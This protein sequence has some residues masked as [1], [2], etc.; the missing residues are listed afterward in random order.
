MRLLVTGSR[1]WKD[2]E[3]L[4]HYLNRMFLQFHDI[5]IVH[6]NCRNGADAMAKEWAETNGIPHEPH[7]AQWDIYGKAAGHIRNKQMVDTNPDRAVAF[8][9]GESRGTRNC[10]SHIEKAGIPYDRFEENSA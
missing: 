5:V 10:I 8:I 4:F 6:G 7:N 9:S 1:K 3:A 2:K